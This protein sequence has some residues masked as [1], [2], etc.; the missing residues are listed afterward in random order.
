MNS[1][2]ATMA[3]GAF[4][5]LALF[6]SIARAGAQDPSPEA[7]LMMY[8]INLARHDP[9]TWQKDNNLVADLSQVAAQMPLAVNRNL[10]GSSTFHATEMATFNYFAHQSAVTGDWPNKMARDNGYVLPAFYPN[11]TNN[12]EGIAAGTTDA[13]STINLLIEDK[14]VNPPGHRIQLLSMDAFNQANREMGVGHAFNAQSTYG[15]YW[16]LHTAWVN[17]TD[18]FLTGVIFNDANSNGLFDLNEGL[19]GVTIANGATSAVTNAAGGWSMPI[20]DGTYTLTA[21]GG[22][23]KGTAT[24]KVTVVGANVEIDFISGNPA[25]I[26]N[27]AKVALNSQ[28]AGTGGNVAVPVGG[29]GLSVIP[30]IT[31]IIG[32]GTDAGGL[33]GHGQQPI[34][35]FEQSQGGGTAPVSVTFDPSCSY[36]PVSLNAAQTYLYQATWDFGDGTVLAVPP[37]GPTADPTQALSVILHGYNAPSI[38]T[39]SLTLN[40]SVLNVGALTGVP[41]QTATVTSQV[42]VATVNFPPTPVINIASSPADGTLPYTLVID[43]SG[44]FDEDGFIM[45]AAI[46]W[47]DGTSQLITPS[48]PGLAALPGPLGTTLQHTYTQPGVYNV[49]LSVIDNGRVPLGSSGPIPAPTSTDPNLVLANLVGYAN[50][51]FPQFSK[52]FNPALK[53]AFLT[54]SIPGSMVVTKGQF[55]VNFTSQGSDAF[56]VMFNSNSTVDSIADAGVVLTLGS[57]PKA[58]T[59]PVFHTDA[60]GH[61]SNQAQGLAFDYNAKKKTVQL[62]ITHAALAAALGLINANVVNGNVDVPVFFTINGSTPLAATVR[63]V[64]NSKQGRSGVGKNARSK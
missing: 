14:G 53:Q 48:A 45:W 18:E 43:P 63:F 19:G 64:Y 49:K 12:I 62:K 50:A 60:R 4:A 28:P 31:T 47:G 6:P 39:V 25:G 21:S 55:K 24:A 54:V 13:R 1:K 44:S 61:F 33:G 58:L 15:D 26:V 11:N 37:S 3:F 7:Q 38:Y 56:N 16:A 35:C 8:L 51:A 9:P 27:F 40:I 42:H 59:L 57:G 22:S 52:L 23:F 5:L 32:A 34:P 10:V 41:G 20:T 17:S 2:T 46:D 29:S 36:L 30:G